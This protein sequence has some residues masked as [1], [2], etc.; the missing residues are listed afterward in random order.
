[1][2]PISMIGSTVLKQ[3][4][5]LPGKPA[6]ALMDNALAAILLL[7]GFLRHPVLTVLFHSFETRQ[8]LAVKV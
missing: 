1:M 3:E 6:N 2:K 8:F 5:S 4:F 7:P